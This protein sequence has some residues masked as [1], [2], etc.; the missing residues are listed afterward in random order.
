M[1]KQMLWNN[2]EVKYVVEKLPG[3][4]GSEELQ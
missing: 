3:E 1:K 2:T 4:N